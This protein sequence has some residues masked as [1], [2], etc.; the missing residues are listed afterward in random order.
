MQVQVRDKT[1]LTLFGGHT[2][3]GVPSAAPTGLPQAPSSTHVPVARQY[4]YMP[5]IGGGGSKSAT[6]SQHGRNIWPISTANLCNV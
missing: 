1:S 6:H 4:T 2:R 5:C 3:S